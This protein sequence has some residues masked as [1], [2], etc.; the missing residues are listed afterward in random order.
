MRKFHNWTPVEVLQ[1]R[2]LLHEGKTQQEIANI[3][4]LPYRT[5][6]G[7]CRNL[8]KEPLAPSALP[9]PVAPADTVPDYAED[10]ERAASD[11]WRKKFKQLEG[12]YEKILHEKSVVDLLVADIRGLAPTSYSA[13]PAIVSNRRPSGTA[14][15]AVLLFSD[16]HVGQSVSLDQTLGFGEYNFSVF[17]SRLKYLEESV[18]SILTNHTTTKI[19]ELVVAMLGDMLH[20]NLKHGAE[21]DQLV[22]LFD[23]YYSAGH[24][25][26]QFFRNLAQHVP[27]L[28]I[29]TCVGNHTRFADQHKMPTGQ[30]YSNFDQF[31]YAYVEA[32]TVD[33]KNIVWDLNRQP[34]ALFAVQNHI[35]RASHGDHLKGGDKAL[36]IPNHS[37]AREI[38]TTTQLFAKHGRQAPHYY[39]C[40]HLHRGIQLPHALGEVIIN[41]GFPGLDNYALAGNFN[42]V[43]PMQ[44]L[45][46]V[47]PKYGRT[48]EYPLSLKFSESFTVPPYDIPAAFLPK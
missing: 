16:T 15:S 36:G 29:H 42:P 30:R 19:D 27:V 5:I 25:I 37:I 22:P 12:K 3:L 39:V 2:T 1:L 34:F 48:A 43:D 17:L 33:I 41:G 44:R 20:G 46:F 9:E 28:K 8:P 6:T 31:L 21:A 11:I 45:L 4:G 18:V 32:L 7:K 47:H 26:A 40:G 13:A 35:F 10:Q 38:S 14:Q 24:A 23:Q